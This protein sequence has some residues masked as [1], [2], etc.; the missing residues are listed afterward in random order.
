M[1]IRQM[2]SM[3]SALILLIMLGS[4]GGGEDGDRSGAF[5]AGA[6]AACPGA[7]LSR[8][9]MLVH[10]S[11]DG[12]DSDN[13]GATPASACKSISQGIRN[14]SRAGCAV[15]V[16]HGLYATNDSV[17]LADGVSVHGSCRFGDEPDWHYRSVIAANP[18]AGEPAILGSGITTPTA[19]TGLVVIGKQETAAGAASIAMTVEASKG[20]ALANMTLAGGRGGDGA[21][22]VTVN[23]AAGAPAGASTLNGGPGGPGCAADPARR[24]AGGTG[25]GRNLA[26]TG[27]CV[28]DCECLPQPAAGVFG[29]NGQDNGSAIGGAG[30][31]SGDNGCGC[32]VRR[33]GDFPRS[34]A[35][36]Q[37]GG[38][39]SC[40]AQGGGKSSLA[41]GQPAFRGR[42]WQAAPGTAGV[43]GA[44]GAGGG[45]GGPGGNAVRDPVFNPLLVMGFGGGGGGGGGC[46]GAGGQ[47]GQQGGASIALA[48]INSSVAGVPEQ[49][50]LLPGAG[51]N[52]GAGAAGGIGGEGGAGAAGGEGSRLGVCVGGNVAAPGLGGAGGNGGRGGAGAGG[53]GGNGGPAIGIALVGNSPDPGDAHVYAGNPGAGGKRGAGGRNAPADF[54]PAPCQGAEGDDG[55]AGGSAAVFR[56]AEGA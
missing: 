8:M 22:G 3:L 18:P 30:G 53:A 39:G 54:D 31:A 20:L 34:G 32:T 51:G 36:G 24:G 9:Q 40:G 56:F 1:P 48:L 13:C 44:G 29:E 38:N 55:I 42:F 15:V 35:N 43:A 46:G 45:G 19:V 6:A 25:S 7:D 2:P 26:T 50:A 41:M 37:R 28:I 5:L 33:N 52:G 17:R 49:L 14:C 16:R 27:S 4:C 21:A 12:S 11:A 23:G 47:G 10:V